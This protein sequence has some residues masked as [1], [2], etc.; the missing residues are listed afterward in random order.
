MTAFIEAAMRAGGLKKEAI[1]QSDGFLD[2]TFL[3]EII[4]LAN[5]AKLN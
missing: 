5:T 3:R 4:S 1:M 2:L